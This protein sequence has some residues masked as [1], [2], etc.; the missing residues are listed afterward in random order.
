MNIETKQRIYDLVKVICGTTTVL[1][2]AKEY[3]DNPI[4]DV[5][6][7]NTWFAAQELLKEVGVS[8]VAAIEEIPLCWNEQVGIRF[9]L[10]KWDKVQNKDTFS[11][12]AGVHKDDPTKFF[13][14]L[15]VE[16]DDG[17]FPVKSDDDIGIHLFNDV[18]AVKDGNIV[19]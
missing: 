4:P 11:L 16:N 7:D 18:W 10:G 13:F 14:E 6:T 5:P 8:S 2:E 17:H 3:F 12:Y 1:P 19:G 15:Y 9:T